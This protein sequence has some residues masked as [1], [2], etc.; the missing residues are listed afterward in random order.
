MT[1]LDFPLNS[2]RKVEDSNE[3]DIENHRAD[4]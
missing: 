1:S 2:I 3:Q 4:R